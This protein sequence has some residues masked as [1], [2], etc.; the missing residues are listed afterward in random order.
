M[1]LIKMRL[2][3]GPNFDIK[4]LMQFGLEGYFFEKKYAFFKVKYR[5]VSSVAKLIAISAGGFGFNS[6][7]GKIGR[8]LANVS[9]LLR[10]VFGAVFSWRYTEDLGTTLVTGFG[11]IS[12]V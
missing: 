5:L 12:Q 1:K 11:V 4:F 7:A 9:S 10:R 2:I 6:P 3:K 8:S